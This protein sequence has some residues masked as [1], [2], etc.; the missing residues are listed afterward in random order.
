MGRVIAFGARTLTGEKPKYRN[1]GETALFKKSSVLYGLHLAKEGIRERRAIVIVEGYMDA[2]SM[3]QAGINNTV[4]TMGA[5]LSETHVPLIKR[6]SLNRSIDV[7]LLFDNDEAGLDG[8]VKADKMLREHGIVA[9][10]YS[11]PPGCDPDD[12]VRQLGVE[13]YDAIV[14]QAKPIPQFHIDTVL[15]QYQREV[16]DLRLDAFRQLIPI[17]SELTGVDRDLYL[18]QVAKTLELREETIKS[19]IIGK[20]VLINTTKTA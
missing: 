14:A 11:M 16:N 15:S 3:H 17:L 19:S 18:S 2:I 12:M 6:L 8:I 10:A 9:N 13:F 7:Y 5:S 4:A 1:T 20:P